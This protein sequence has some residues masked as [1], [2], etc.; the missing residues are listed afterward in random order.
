[1]EKEEN[2]EDKQGQIE[3][4]KGENEGLKEEYEDKQVRIEELLK[5]YWRYVKMK[6]KNEKWRNCRIVTKV[7]RRSW[8][9]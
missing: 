8:N 3:E 5:Y 6:S 1:M 2:N 4:L 7:S 9:G